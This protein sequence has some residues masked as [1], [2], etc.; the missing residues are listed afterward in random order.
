[1]RKQAPQRIRP[2]RLV[3]ALAAAFPAWALAQSPAAAPP[4]PLAPPAAAASAPSAAGASAAAPAARTAPRITVTATRIEEA[5]DQVAATV[6]SRTAQEIGRSQAR[7]LRT[8][9]DS[10]PGIAVRQQPARMSA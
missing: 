1:M 7:D 4:S 10:E 9:L 2:N 8:L 6:T 3:A 5:E